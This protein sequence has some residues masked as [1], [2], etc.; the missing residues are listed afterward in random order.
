[1]GVLW[2]RQADVQRSRGEG[3]PTIP[4]TLGDEKKLNPFL[5]ADVPELKKRFGGEDR[6]PHEIFGALRKAK[7]NF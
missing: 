2:R 3:K 4:A 5:R 7:D 1:M 6:T